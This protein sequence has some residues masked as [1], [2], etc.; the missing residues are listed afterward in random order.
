M[1]VSWWLRTKRLAL[2]HR[3]RTERE[4]ASV[5]RKKREAR[6]FASPALFGP[7]DCIAA[8]TLHTHTLLMLYL[9]YLHTASTRL[10]ADC[11]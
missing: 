4:H 5:S 3:T 6:A 2:A 10:D 8:F 11:A 1:A 9:L 7:R